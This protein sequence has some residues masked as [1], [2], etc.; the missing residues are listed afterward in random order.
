MLDIGETA[1]GGVVAFL[2][3]CR[4]GARFADGFERDARRLVGFGKGCLRLGE[5]VGGGAALGPSRVSISPI[6]A[7]RWLSNFCGAFSSSV[8]SFDSLAVA[9]ADSVDLRGG[10]VL[11]LVPRRAFGDDGLQ[12]AIGKLD[13]ARDRLRFDPHLGADIALGC[14]HIVDCRKPVFDLGGRRQRGK[15]GVRFAARGAGLVARR[16]GALPRFLER[17]DARRV[18]ADLAFGGGMFFARGIGQA[19]RLAPAR[20]G[21]GFGSRRGGD[22][23]FRGFDACGACASTSLR[24]AASSPSIA[25]S[26]PRSASRRAA[27][28]GAC[29][30]TAKPSQRHKSPSRETSRW[31]GLSIAGEARS[32]GALDDADLGEAARQFGRRL[33]ILRQGG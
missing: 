24:A 15:G 20:A 17:R 19:L 31:P 12:P 16:D 5:P 30:A 33:H 28:V 10:I 4:F 3:A 11:A 1:L 32:V 29:A 23:G 8:R 18:A 13:L 26:R 2:A 27:P 6:S 7:W 25:C 22:C 9:L 14:D 21:L